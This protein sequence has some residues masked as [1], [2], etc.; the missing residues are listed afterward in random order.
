LRRPG[1]PGAVDLSTPEAHQL[2]EQ[3]VAALGGIDVL[4]N[5]VGIGDTADVTRA[6][7]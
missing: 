6:R 7:C 2:V 3:A 5:N 1:D 4:I